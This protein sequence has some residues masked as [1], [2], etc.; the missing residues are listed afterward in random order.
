VGG[1]GGEAGIKPSR[2]K[3]CG[4]WDGAGPAGSGAAASSGALP[5][6]CNAP[7]PP[8]P[9]PALPRR[10]C[11]FVRSQ[12]GTPAAIVPPRPPLTR[13]K[14]ELAVAAEGQAAAAAGGQAPSG[15]AKGRSKVS[16]VNINWLPPL[17]ATG[18]RAGRR[19]WAS[20]ERV[21]VCG[22]GPLELP[23]CRARC[24]A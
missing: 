19:R 10:Y 20:C 7:P 24:R 1:G 18:E 16:E 23:A 21:C 8:P 5:S 17:G 11:D 14:R 4:C 15:L 12:V 3:G 13:Y 2:G 22:G 6:T 9:A